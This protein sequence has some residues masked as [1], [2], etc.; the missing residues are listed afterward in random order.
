MLT[1][2]SPSTLS[3]AS[4]PCFV[5]REP[6]QMFHLLDFCFRLLQ[7]CDR[8]RHLKMHIIFTK[9]PGAHR[10]LLIPFESEEVLVQILLPISGIAGRQIS[11]RIRQSRDS[12]P[13]HSRREPVI[14]SLES[15]KFF[16]ISQQPI[17]Q[18]VQS[19]V[20]VLT[21]SSHLC[22]NDSVQLN[23]RISLDPRPRLPACLSISTLLLP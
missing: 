11:S 1:L 16:H 6:D 17:A 23:H 3:H 2:A 10:F 21:F 20:P 8:S 12:S 7:T 9:C 13:N 18:H 15:S 19:P 14:H 5:R 22:T 4:R